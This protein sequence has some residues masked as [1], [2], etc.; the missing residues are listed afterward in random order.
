MLKKN[1]MFRLHIII[2]VVRF[3]ASNGGDLKTFLNAYEACTM[4][5]IICLIASTMLIL[6]TSGCATNR[7]G[8]GLLGLGLFSGGNSQGGLFQGSQLSNNP[9]RSFF[10]GAPC[11][12][13]NP[14][15]GQV[16]GHGGNVAPLCNDGSCYGG[17]P[18]SAP[19]N[20]QLNDPGV[21]YYDNGS[22]IVP[23]SAIPNSGNSVLPQ[24]TIVP[25]S[26]QGVFSGSSSR[27]PYGSTYGS[28]YE[29][30]SLPSIEALSN[31]FDADAM[32]PL[33]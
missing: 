8:N 4:K 32:P 17:A 18:V 10:R 20:I 27:V 6:S 26:G 9:I 16:G 21:P 7:C 25:N 5:K 14:P 28:S 23:Q 31:S 13:C 24:G 3:R 1:N 29:S 30:N 11:D 22:G 12:T 33:P 15:A 19:A 2:H